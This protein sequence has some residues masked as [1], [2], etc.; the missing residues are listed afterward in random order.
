MNGLPFP[1]PWAGRPWPPDNK[2][3]ADIG[4]E[5]QTRKKEHLSFL[6]KRQS[7]PILDSVGSVFFKKRKEKGAKKQKNP[8]K[9]LT[10]LGFYGIVL[11]NKE[12]ESP[13][14]PPDNGSRTV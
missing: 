14:S 13:L 11:W 1:A 12:E 6:Q 5:E 4:R 9:V 8:K 10:T 2:P 3:Y 7:P